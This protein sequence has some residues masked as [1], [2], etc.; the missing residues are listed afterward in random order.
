MVKC[1]PKHVLGSF[2]VRSDGGM[3]AGMVAP[4]Y[5]RTNLN[6]CIS[7][8]IVCM[9]SHIR[10]SVRYVYIAYIYMYKVVVLVVGSC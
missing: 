5:K 2:N 6:A 10:L 8:V 1:L 3:V 7:R 4:P 9:W